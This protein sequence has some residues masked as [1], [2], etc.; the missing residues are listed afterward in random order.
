METINLS[1]ET[2]NKITHWRVLGNLKG[3]EKPVD[4]TFKKSRCKKPETALARFK[5][6]LSGNC[7]NIIV[8]GLLV[9]AETKPIIFQA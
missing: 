3:I 6:R 5:K 4:L 7:S 1:T 2:E 9:H 8:T